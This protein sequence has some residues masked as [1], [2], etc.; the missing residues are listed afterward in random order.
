VWSIPHRRDCHSTGTASHDRP[1]LP[2]NLVTTLGLRVH[3]VSVARSTVVT[4]PVRVD[5]DPKPDSL[6]YSLAFNHNSY[7]YT[8]LLSRVASGSRPA[9]ETPLKQRAVERAL[10]SD[11]SGHAGGRS[12]AARRSSAPPTSATPPSRRLCD[13]KGW[14]TF[15]KSTPAG[16]NRLCPDRVWYSPASAH[17]SYSQPYYTSRTVLWF[18]SQ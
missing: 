4:L 2:F 12:R 16:C 9:P 7:S 11:Q 1:V 13:A 10:C 15:R 14:H 3:L 18:I 8:L 5:L 6:R 17:T